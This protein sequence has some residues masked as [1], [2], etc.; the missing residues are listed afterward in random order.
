MLRFSIL[1]GSECTRNG[2]LKSD[3]PVDGGAFQRG[4]WSERKLPSD[5]SK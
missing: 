5:L 2:V 4:V 1:P 3:F